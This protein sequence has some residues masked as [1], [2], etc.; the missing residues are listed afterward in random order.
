MNADLE[1]LTQAAVD[2]QAGILD[3]EFALADVLNGIAATGLQPSQIGSAVGLSTYRVR[4]Y[5]RMAEAFP[6]GHRHPN[7]T[8][9]HYRVMLTHPDSDRLI[10]ERV[11]C[12]AAD[13]NWSTRDL[14]KQIGWQGA[15]PDLDQ[16]AK[17]FR[18]DADRLNERWRGRAAFE[19]KV[20]IAEE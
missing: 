13:E 5:L 15:L 2:L 8:M 17:I 20:S 19:A 11:C 14:K 16:D 6:E 1:Q 10:R 18:R 4:N 9:Q 12:K 7:L 3:Q